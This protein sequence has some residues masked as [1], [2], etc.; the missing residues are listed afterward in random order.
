MIKLF[1][2]LGES[3]KKF[4]KGSRGRNAKSGESFSG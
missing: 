1:E 3:I 4:L 2:T